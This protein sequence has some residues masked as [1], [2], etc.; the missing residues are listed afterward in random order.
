MLQQ[1]Q[2]L[3]TTIDYAGTPGIFAQVQVH[4]SSPV[5]QHPAVY[6]RICRLRRM[7]KAGTADPAELIARGIAP[8][9]P[10]FVRPATDRTHVEVVSGSAAAAVDPEEPPLKKSKKQQKRASS[11]CRDA[12]RAAEFRGCLHLSTCLPS[13]HLVAILALQQQADHPK[14]SSINKASA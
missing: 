3:H 7:R 2:S 6:R 8:V 9:K 10:A 14:P 1:L 5:A 12:S 13:V 4:I 11:C